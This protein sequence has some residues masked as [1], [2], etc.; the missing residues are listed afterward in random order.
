MIG[1][2]MG[3]NL[4]ILI[5]LVLIAGIYFREGISVTGRGI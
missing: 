4:I 2:P 3:S 5:F 1:Y